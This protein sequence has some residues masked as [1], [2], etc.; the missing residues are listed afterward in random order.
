MRRSRQQTRCTSHKNHGTLA[1]HDVSQPLPAVPR[2]AGRRARRRHH[3]AHRRLEAAPGGNPGRRLR[4]LRPVRRSDRDRPRRRL[5][6]RVRAEFVAGGHGGG[7]RPH[8]SG[9]PGIPA[10]LRGRGGQAPLRA[11]ARQDGANAGLPSPIPGHAAV[12]LA[13]EAGPG[14]RGVPAPRPAERRRNPGRIHGSEA[15]PRIP[16]LRRG[17]VRR[18]RVRGRPR[19]AFPKLFALERDHRSLIL[20]GIKLRNSSGG[21]R[22][23]IL[24]FP[25]GLEEL[26]RA[27]AD[28]LGGAIRLG[29]RV[30]ALERGESGWSVAFERAGDTHLEAFSAVICALPADQLARL[31]LGGFATPGAFSPLSEIEHPPVASGFTGFRGGDVAHA[32]DGFG[33]LVPRAEGRNILG[34]LFSSSLFPG[35][36][37]AGHVALTT[38][39]GGTRQSAL[40]R[41]DDGALIKLVQA[42]LAALLGAREAPVL[43]RV[44]RH[45]RAI[46]QYAV[47]FDRYK[48]IFA[49]AEASAPGLYI[50]GNCRDG[51]SVSACV[52]SGCRL[53]QAVAALF[54]PSPVAF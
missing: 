20:G 17:P 36:A 35:R 18:R 34:T 5:A 31:R 42:E 43:V 41:L 16:G 48:A 54:A 25:E 50:G 3:G 8:R 32:L 22:G 51:I 37:P 30:L 40:A 9:W 1:I 46:P 4:G 14:L 49:A 15:R 39:V 2:P 12:L 52:A 19:H 44:R 24:S 29:T 45:A 26:P 53:A 13:G 10:P 6:A 7:I 38:F 47:G 21:P 27:L 28:Q 23:R 33:V 11:Q